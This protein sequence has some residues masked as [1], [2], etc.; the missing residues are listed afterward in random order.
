MPTRKTGPGK[1]P[2]SPSTSLSRKSGQRSGSG[3]RAKTGQR[4]SRGPGRRGASGLAE[5]AH[6]RLFAL[7][8][9]AGATWTLA[10]VA[11]T[12]SFVFFVPPDVL[13]IPM[14]LAARKRAWIV[15]SICTVASVL[16]ALVGYGIGY[17]AFDA[18]GEPLLEFYGH[19]E[20]FGAF[21][22]DYNEYGAWAVLV[23][24]FTPFPFKAI[25]ILS[26]TTELSLPVFVLSCIV[27]RGAR[28]FLV[29]ALLW[30]FGE[31]ARAFVEKRLGLLMG[32]I[33]LVAIAIAVALI[34]LP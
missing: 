9:S 6:G 4:K 26:G 23:G 11:F 28:F 33:V 16:G 19:T 10:L 24:G 22:S 14:V 27:A 7:A 2:A 20:R 5:R 31:S 30:R 15:A 29:A 34:F 3:A 1:P 13:L 17:L 12:E 18:L 25:T 21:A 32:A 8:A